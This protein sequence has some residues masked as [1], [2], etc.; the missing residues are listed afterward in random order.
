MSTIR[1]ATAADRDRLVEVWVRSV[2]AT[3]AFLGEQDVQDRLPVVRDVV[4]AGEA[5][6]TCLLP[7]VRFRAGRSLGTRFGRTAF[8]H[9][10]LA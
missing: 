10:S 2:R 4:L 7:A 6:G 3:H 8:P 9:P 5:A 1:R